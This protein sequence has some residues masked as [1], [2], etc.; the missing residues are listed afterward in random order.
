MAASARVATDARVQRLATLAEWL[1]QPEELGAELIGGR[2]V[3]KAMPSPEHGRAQRKLGEA[4]GPFD[5]RTSGSGRPGGW[6]LAS[7]VDVV[8]RGEGVRPDLLDLRR[9]RVPELPRPSP[10]GAVT[11][12][13]DWIAE[14]LSS[15]TASRDLGD[16]LVLYHAAEVPHYWIVDPNNHTLLVYRWLREGYIAVLGA[17]SDKIVRAEPFEALELHVGLL[18]GDDDDVMGVTAER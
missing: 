6:W 8:L 12:R 14:V 16:K 9:D 17:G 11:E 15:S 3:Y 18:F 1:A 13:P 4:L 7:E 10:G 5:S 2:I